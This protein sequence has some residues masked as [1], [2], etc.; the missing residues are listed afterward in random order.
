LGVEIKFPSYTLADRLEIISR[1]EPGSETYIECNHNL[2]RFSPAKD[3]YYAWNEI[4]PRWHDLQVQ[5][6]EL[7][8]GIK[9]ACTNSPEWVAAGSE[10][11]DSLS[12][13]PEKLR[14]YA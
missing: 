6:E 1:F 7:L 13:R 2:S 10:E 12:W 8:A 9:A 3:R 4:E 14:A 11:Q 5:S